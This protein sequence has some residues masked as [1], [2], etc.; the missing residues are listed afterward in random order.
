[1]ADCTNPQQQRQKI[2]Q[3]NAFFARGVADAIPKWGPYS[4]L[5]IAESST[6]QSFR[7][8]DHQNS[9]YWWILRRKVRPKWKP[10][11]VGPWPLCPP[12]FV[13]T[14]PPKNNVQSLAD[15]V[16]R[17]VKIDCT[18]LIFINP[19]VKIDEIYYCDNSYCL[20]QVYRSL[21]NSSFSEVFPFP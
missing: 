12:A 21:A 14:A 7:F 19:R 15:C 3:Q 20:M 9:T 5:K 11:K 1:M 17:R 13:A 18:G 10:L 4:C 8:F 2:L 16:C 6:G